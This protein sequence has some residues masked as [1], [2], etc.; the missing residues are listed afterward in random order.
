MF[1]STGSH[2]F[3]HQTSTRQVDRSNKSRRHLQQ[4]YKCMMYT[5]HMQRSQM[6]RYAM[7]QRIHHALQQRPF[8]NRPGP[9]VEVSDLSSPA[10][11]L[12]R[13]A[14][15]IPMRPRWFHRALS[16]IVRRSRVIFT[17]RPICTLLQSKPCRIE[18]FIPKGRIVH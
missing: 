2:S 14:A 11:E 12:L 13:R 9:G 8:Q 15:A 1:L 4:C 17:L 10:H 5:C 7:H 18:I 6:G 16:F 3:Q